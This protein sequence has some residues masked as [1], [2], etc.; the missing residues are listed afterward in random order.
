VQ[1]LILA[2]VFVG[3]VLLLVGTIAFVNR[4]RLAA[5]DAVRSRLKVVG[6]APGATPSILRDQRASESAVLNRLLTG[7]GYT[8]WATAELARAGSKRRPGDLLTMSALGAVLGLVFG[9]LL[10]VGPLA[11]VFAGL[12]A[13]LPFLNL[14]RMQTA[15]V[16]KFEDQLPRRSRCS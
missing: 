13:A 12:G 14:K 5:S 6:D 16:R 3:T 7:K 4:R 2:I 15:R 1:L 8:A 11:L 10:A 9:Q